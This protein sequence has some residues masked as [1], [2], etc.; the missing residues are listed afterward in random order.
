LD[1]PNIR[2]EALERRIFE[3]DSAAIDQVE[4]QLARSRAGKASGLISKKPL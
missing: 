4:Q 2:L 1:N 3:Q